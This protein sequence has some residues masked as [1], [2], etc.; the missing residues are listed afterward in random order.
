MQLDHLQQ[1]SALQEHDTEEFF[2][3]SAC[4]A[5][6]V[7]FVDVEFGIGWDKWH[8]DYH[9]I[10]CSNVVVGKQT[11]KGSAKSE[12]ESGCWFIQA[13]VTGLETRLKL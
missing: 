2:W 9:I 7:F 5:K 11:P 3:W 1:N 6:C 12:R 8:F 10:M 4:V 13:Q